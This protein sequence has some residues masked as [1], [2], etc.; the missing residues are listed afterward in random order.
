[1]TRPTNKLQ[2]RVRSFDAAT[3]RQ[4]EREK[5]MRIPTEPVVTRDWRREDLYDRDIAADDDV[6]Q[7]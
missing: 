3:A 1:M 2:E 4:R 5:R 6:E 7:R